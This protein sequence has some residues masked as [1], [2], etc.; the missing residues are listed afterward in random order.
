[1]EL[2]LR[3]NRLA[4]VHV[5]FP[6]ASCCLCSTRMNLSWVGQRL[7]MAT[8][9]LNALLDEVAGDDESTAALSLT[10]RSTGSYESDRPWVAQ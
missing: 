1:M 7:A 8:Q 2:E 6:F 5:N 9:R 10:S 4:A 3:Q